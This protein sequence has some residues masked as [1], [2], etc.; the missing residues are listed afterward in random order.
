MCCW[1][2]GMKMAGPA[3]PAQKRRSQPDRRS[4]PHSQL[5]A[6]PGEKTNNK[7]AISLPYRETPKVCLPARK[8]RLPQA[9]PRP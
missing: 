5:L 4:L 8:Q 6:L 7:S 2:I 3:S 1:G 9:P